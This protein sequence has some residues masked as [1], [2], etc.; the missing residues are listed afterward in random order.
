MMASAPWSALF[1]V[2]A[3][4]T[5][6]FRILEGKGPE[7]AHPEV[8]TKYGRLRGT[9]ASVK[10]T[11][12]LVDVFLG[13]PFA[14]PPT[15]SL[16]FSSPQPPEPWDGV[17]DA[18]TYPAVCPQD[19]DILKGIQKRWKEKHPPFR[20]SEDCLYLNIYTPADS[21]KASKLPVM[22]WIHGG[23]MIFGAASRFDGSALAAYE[24]VVV[25]ILQYRLGILGFFSTGDESARG[26]WAL[27]DQL[28]A[29]QWIQENIGAFGGDPELVTLFGVSAGSMSA[30]AHVMSPLSKGLFHRAILES[31]VSQL[32]IVFQNRSKSAEK[33]ARIFGCEM[34]T[35]AAL[36]QCLRQ[37]SEQELI[38]AD[39][40]R[41]GLGPALDGVFMPKTPEEILAGREV[42]AVPLMVGVTNHEFGW[43][44]RV[45]GSLEGFK[46]VGDR[47]K[48]RTTLEAILPI[49]GIPLELLPMVLDEYLGD[50]NDLDELR[51]GFLDLIGDVFI[52]IPSIKTLRYH[53]ETGAPTYFFEY[54]HRPSLYHDTKP[55]Y[56]KADHA[57]EVGFVFGGPFLT[58]DIRLHGDATEEEK[59]LSR[60][61]MKYW[62]NFAR[63]GNPN[64]EGLVEWPAYNTQEQY[65]EINLKQKVSMKL[66]EKKV[67]FWLKTVP[68]KVD[69]V[70]RKHTEL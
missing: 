38:N 34:T 16:R 27:L 19:L 35:S 52:V 65:L 30:S 61:M 13:I 49:L 57:D 47:D 10:G 15:G 48:I 66:K 45:T 44:S 24:D 22:V 28:A 46:D 50:T 70:R 4:S 41:Q 6:G 12:R 29:L 25:V 18:T 26:N 64:G 42:S 67:E 2:A 56:V 11:E 20:S 14:K 62:A 59:V 55:D 40:S 3:I 36:V 39:L 21:P 9:Q 58:G 5:V 53:R 37:K 23:N 32:P 1:W 69:E 31:G 63:S 51:D 33:I 43:N 17:R 7:G 60:T 54:Q 8:A 68:E